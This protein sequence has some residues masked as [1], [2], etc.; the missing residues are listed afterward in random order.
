MLGAWADMGDNI[1][2]YLSWNGLGGLDWIYLAE[3]RDQ[4]QAVVDTAMNRR[5]KKGQE[6]L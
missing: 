5:F 3:D 2:T 6:T 1:K 4:R